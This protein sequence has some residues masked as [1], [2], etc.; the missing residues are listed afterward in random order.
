M[1]RELKGD[2]NSLYDA[3]IELNVPRKR[4]IQLQNLLH[5][6]NYATFAI[7]CSAEDIPGMDMVIITTDIAADQLPALATAATECNTTL[8]ILAPALDYERRTACQAIVEAHRCTSVD[9]HGYLLLFNN[10]LPKQIFR[11]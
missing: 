8:C 7:D 11:L 4:C 9:N 5:H 2:D 1:C 10:H 3:L 6:C